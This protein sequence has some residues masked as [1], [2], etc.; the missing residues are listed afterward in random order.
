M[1]IRALKDVWCLPG[2]TVAHRAP[3]EEPNWASNL[4][5]RHAAVLSTPLIQ[6]LPCHGG[7]GR[8][9]IQFTQQQKKKPQTHSSIPAEHCQL[10]DMTLSEKDEDNYRGNYFIFIMCSASFFLFLPCSKLID[11]DWSQKPKVIACSQPESSSFNV[12]RDSIAGWIISMHLMRFGLACNGQGGPQI[13][14]LD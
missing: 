7:T 9:L 12:P 5:L 14:H 11:L 4:S 13:S 10:L 6:S 8:A 1:V 3:I 2:L